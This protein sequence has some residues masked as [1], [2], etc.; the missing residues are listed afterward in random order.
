MMPPKSQLFHTSE[1]AAVAAWKEVCRLLEY[2][3]DGSDINELLIRL[4]ELSIIYGDPNKQAPMGV[5]N[6]PTHHP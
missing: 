2:Y 6:A 1:E 4:Y 3:G 5:L